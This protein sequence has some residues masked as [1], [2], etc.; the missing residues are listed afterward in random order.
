MKRLILLSLLASSAAAVA[1]NDQGYY[2]GLGAHYIDSG[3][4]S[5]T[6]DSIG[7]SAVELMG[8]YKHSSLIGGEL[9]LGTSVSEAETLGTEFTIPQFVSLYYRAELAND[10]AKSFL[11]LGFT[12][13]E[14][15]RTD[16]ET[17]FT[18]KASD[19]GLSYGAGIGFVVN[20]K[21]NLNFEYIRLISNDD[22][23]FDSLGIT[24]DYRF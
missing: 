10:V 21:V 4:I 2:L 19:S 13:L 6:A 7:F 5:D 23:E 8:G 3:V 22:N 14:V 9:R 16:I 24:L 17:G 20:S 11:L 1:D 12:D 15:E 18:D